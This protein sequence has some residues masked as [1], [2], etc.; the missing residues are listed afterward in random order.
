[1][2]KGSTRYF[3]LNSFIEEQKTWEYWRIFMSISLCIWTSLC[4]RSFSTL[5][6]EMNS[7]LPSDSYSFLCSIVT[8]SSHD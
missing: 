3:S 4:C 1:V 5:V 2:A 6:S 7:F 8:G